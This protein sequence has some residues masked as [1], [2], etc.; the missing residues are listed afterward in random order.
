MIEV[1]ATMRGG[2]H[3]LARIT[4]ENLLDSPDPALGNYSVRFAVDTAEGYALYQRTVHN[5]PRKQLNAL[6]LIRLALE[7]LDEKELSLDADPDASDSPN[8]ARR[9]P[10]TM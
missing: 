9:L 7:S 3:E 6:A 1:T 8:L 10:R 2:K 5:F 4:I